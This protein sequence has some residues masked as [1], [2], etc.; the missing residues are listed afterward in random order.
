[1]HNTTNQQQLLKR[2][3]FSVLSV[4]LLVGFDQW[5]KLLAVNGL[6][7]KEPF[8]IFSGILELL[9]VENRGAAFGIL[10][11][12]QWLFFAIAAFVCV[13]LIR[14]ILRLPNKRRYLP[15]GA[16]YVF[17]IAGALGNLIDRMRQ[18]F[19][20]DFIYFMPIDFPVFN[21]A[22]IYI[23]CACAALVA[24]IFFYYKDDETSLS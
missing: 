22:D 11:G 4:A 7:S 5:T 2:L 12:K 10:K 1:M 9:Y 21:V 15:L 13:A 18:G 17:I 8:V 6:K 16:C 23:T 24:L 19:V 14:L 3:S 20:V